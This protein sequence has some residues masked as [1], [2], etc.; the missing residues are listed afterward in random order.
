MGLLRHSLTPGLASPITHPERESMR[1]QDDRPGPGLDVMEA[2]T[3]HDGL[4]MTQFAH[5]AHVR[6]LPKRSRR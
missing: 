6:V 5:R 3:I 2:Q 1:Q 4:A